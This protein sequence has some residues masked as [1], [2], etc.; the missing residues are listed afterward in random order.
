MPK[1]KEEIMRGGI[2]TLMCPIENMGEPGDN[3][4][5]KWLKD[6]NLTQNNGGYI[7]KNEILRI[8]VCLYIN[9]NLNVEMGA[10]Q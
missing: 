6:G 7:Y 4:E 2:I 3:Q 10:T 5:Y 9:V 8:M 1:P